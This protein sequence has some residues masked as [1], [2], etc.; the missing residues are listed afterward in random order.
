MYSLIQY[1]SQSALNHHP[2][3]SLNSIIIAPQLEECLPKINLRIIV[4]LGQAT[5]RANKYSDQ[6]D[7]IYTLQQQLIVDINCRALHKWLAV[8]Y[9]SVI[10]ISPN[11]P[12]HPADDDDKDI[13]F[14]GTHF[15]PPHGYFSHPPPPLYSPWS[16]LRHVLIM[17]DYVF[18]THLRPSRSVFSP[19]YGGGDMEDYSVSTRTRHNAFPSSSQAI[20]WRITHQPTTNILWFIISMVAS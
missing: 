18:T 5:S 10:A 9:G 19:D 12:H 15:T 17:S 7:T 16:L 1:H 14:F 11:H 3:H 8:M 13:T 2:P 4:R 20:R 6:G